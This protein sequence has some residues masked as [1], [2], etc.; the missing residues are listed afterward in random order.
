MRLRSEKRQPGMRSHRRCGDCGVEFEDE[1]GAEFRCE[2][3]RPR[4]SLIA[5]AVA[6]AVRQKRRTI[7]QMQRE[8]R[9]LERVIREVERLVDDESERHGRHPR[10]D[11]ADLEASGREDDVD[12]GSAA[13][14]RPSASNPGDDQG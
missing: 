4:L 10:E 5:R 13:A 7:E 8:A 12:I 2:D 3:C 14:H 11:V 6:D 1:T 9:V